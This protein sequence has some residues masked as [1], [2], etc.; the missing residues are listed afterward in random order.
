MR[1]PSPP[2]SGP[3]ARHPAFVAESGEAGV[4]GFSGLIAE[5]PELDLLFVAAAGR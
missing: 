5:P 2:R 4:L 3:T 1:R